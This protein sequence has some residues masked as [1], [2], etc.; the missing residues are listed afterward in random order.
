MANVP[1]KIETALKILDIFVN[2]FNCRASHV[3][4]VNN[5]LAVWHKKGLHW[6]DFIPGMEFAAE[7][8]WVEILPNGYSFKL[9]E[10]GFATSPQQNSEINAKPAIVNKN[11]I[12]I[13]QA[14][15]SPIT[16][17]INSTQTVTTN[18]TPISKDELVDFVNSFRE[19]ISDLKLST[20]EERK[21]NA[22][23]ATI[24]AQLLDEPNPEVL[25]QTFA[26]IKNI[27]EGAIG[28]LLA[29]AAQPGVWAAI[30]SFLSSC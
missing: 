14:I 30:Q 19:H 15:N 7:Q 12:S 29:T 24:E 8:K 20:Q 3:L 16:Q 2:H 22:Q 21:V 25:K 5:F 6:D 1:S 28:S 9:T 11:Y 23:L 17:G 10:E 4:R 18:Y 26:S 13:G 27:T